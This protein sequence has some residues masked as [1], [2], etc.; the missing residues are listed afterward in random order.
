[1]KC[2]TCEEIK[3]MKNSDS[4][5]FH[6]VWDR[7]DKYE[8]HIS[9]LHA[10]IKRWRFKYGNLCNKYNELKKQSEFVNTEIMPNIMIEKLDAKECVLKIQD[11]TVTKMRVKELEAEISQLKKELG[12]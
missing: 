9:E 11:Y 7:E 6:H 4:K 5:L 2:K 8:D 10:E 12:K 1:M 3:E